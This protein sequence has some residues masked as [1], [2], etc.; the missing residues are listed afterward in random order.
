VRS[1]YGDVAEEVFAP[2]AGVVLFLTV[3]PPVPADGLLL[4]LGAGLSPAS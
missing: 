3:S 4:G 2:E 1:L